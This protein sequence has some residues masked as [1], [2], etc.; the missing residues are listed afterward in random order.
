MFL[1]QKVVVRD[2]HYSCAFVIDKKFILVI[3]D[4]HKPFYLYGIPSPMA[5]GKMQ[6][7]I[8]WGYNGRFI[9]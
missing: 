4:V 6:T 9:I 3:V 5:R 7:A 1:H 8:F 2:R